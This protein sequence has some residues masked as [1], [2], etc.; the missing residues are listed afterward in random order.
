M[1]QLPTIV[2]PP[3][4]ASSVVSSVAGL[5]HIELGANAL[6]DHLVIFDPEQSRVGFAA[7]DC[8]QRTCPQGP[9]WSD[10]ATADDVAHNLA[11]CSNRG[12]CDRA[13]GVCACYKDFASSDGRWSPYRPGQSGREL[14]LHHF[15]ASARF[16]RIHPVEAGWMTAD[17]RVQKDEHC[18]TGGHFE[19]TVA[20]HSSEP[21]SAKGRFGGRAAPRGRRTCCATR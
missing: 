13:T 9:A 8:S 16:V 3:I 6:I 11:E 18:H 12:T 19:G 5:R 7:A 14:N 17:V 1:L 2:S 15:D 4:V 20:D 10:A 21:P